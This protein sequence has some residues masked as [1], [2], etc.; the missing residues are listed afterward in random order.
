MTAGSSRKSGTTVSG[1]DGA[2]EFLSAFSETAHEGAPTEGHEGE[3]TQKQ[4]ADAKEYSKQKKC[5]YRKGIE[6]C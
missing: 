5:G 4:A 6:S 2:V 3:L 1:Y